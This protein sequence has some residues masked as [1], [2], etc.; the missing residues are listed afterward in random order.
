MVF[1][2]GGAFKWG[3]GN[4]KVYHGE[5]LAKFGDVVVVDTDYR[6]GLLGYLYTGDDDNDAHGNF[7]LQD[8]RLALQWVK[9]NIRNFGG[10]PEKVILFGQSAGAQSTYAHMM[11][12]RSE[13][14]FRG[15]IV[16]SAPF[17]L[18]YRTKGEALIIAS[19]VKEMARCEVGDVMECLRSKSAEEINDIQE[20]LTFRIT[21]TKI[22]EYFEP[23]GPVLDGNDVSSQPMTAAAKGYFQKIPIML[24]TVSEE[25]RLFVYGVWKLKL[26]KTEYELAIDGLHPGHSEA[27]NK[28]Y[29][30]KPDENDFRDSLS[31]IV[32]DSLFLC[33]TMNASI[34]MVQNG[35]VNVF[36]YL[37]DHATVEHGGWGKDSFCEGHVCHAEELGFLFGNHLA[38]NPTPDEVILSETLMIY[39]TNFAHS[40]DPNIGKYSPAMTWPAFRPNSTHI[41][42]FQT[43]QNNILGNYR[44][45]YCDVWDKIGYDQVYR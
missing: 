5:H 12:R 37:F 13:G 31:L 10:D 24:G 23:I 3:S 9:Q 26:T 28:L 40:L 19:K 41:L 39:W 32:T 38:G 43:P 45:E 16:E 18:P 27:I 22:D 35:D 30:P 11:S 29:P 8:Q 36:A 2:H 6:I 20:K 21:G 44:K 14:L 42:H 34:N 4:N 15:V 25:G 7:G 1:I 33:P 17:A